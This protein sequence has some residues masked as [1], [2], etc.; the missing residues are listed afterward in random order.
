LSG[1]FGEEKN[2]SH[3]AAGLELRI[4][5]CVA[6]SKQVVGSNLGFKWCSCNGIVSGL[7]GRIMWFS[8][9]FVYHFVSSCGVL[10]VS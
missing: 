8:F 2:K 6:Q 10:T 3:A 5:Q 7:L 4:I 1:H 9:W